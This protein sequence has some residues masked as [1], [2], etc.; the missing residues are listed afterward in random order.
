MQPSLS[1]VDV[2]QATVA[3]PLAKDWLGKLTKGKT[4]HT[5][6]RDISFH[7]DQR[8]HATVFG[9]S[10]A[11]K[12]TLLRLLTGQAPLTA[13]TV[14]VNGQAPSAVKHLAA[15]YVGPSETE[16]ATESAHQILTTFARTHGTI[17]PNSRIASVSD[18]LDMSSF[19]HR[20]AS[21][22]SSSEALLLNIARAAVSD[23]PLILL[24]D[25]VEVLGVT[26]VKQILSQLFS[27]RAAL[28]TARMASQAEQLE[29][30]LMLMHQGTLARSGTL[31]E[32]SAA[33]STPRIVD[34][35]IEGLR[36]DVL[37]K[38]RKHSGVVDAI[39]LPTTNFSGQRLRVTLV[40]SRY[41]P[42]L[43]DLVSQTPLIEVKEVP[44]SL[45]DVLG[46]L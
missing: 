44:P 38:L 29:L 36:Y 23:A 1:F 18:A 5:A 35:W 15:G 34:V 13:G 43:Y 4:S 20:P 32:I 17:R 3:Y 45:N 6:I 31:D 10:A 33:V 16:P 9:H 22:L 14:I 19:L 25:V 7:M 24:D 11:G 46:R 12:T 8:T 27:Q 40:S 30:P 26:K 39:L 21:S 28:V 37:R 42:A 2:R 41:L